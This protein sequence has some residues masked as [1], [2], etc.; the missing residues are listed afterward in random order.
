MSNIKT[1]SKAEAIQ[2]NEMPQPLTKSEDAQPSTSREERMREL[3]KDRPIYVNSIAAGLLGLDHGSVL[4]EMQNARGEMIRFYMSEQGGKLSAEEARIRVDTYLEDV[5][6]AV[7]H[8]LSQPADMSTWYGL[9]K[10]YAKSPAHAKTVWR[11][12]KDE[13]RLEFESGHRAAKVFEPVHWLREAWRRAQYIAIRESF[14]EQWKPQGGIDLAMIDMLTQSFYL[15]LYWN[16][17]SVTRTETE[18]RAD[19]PDWI[20]ERAYRD[21]QFP[22]ERGHGYWNPPYAHE[23]EAVEHAAQMADRYQRAFQRTLRAMRDLRRYSTPV[24]INN[25]Q[26]VN[27]AADGGRQVNAMKVGAHA[28]DSEPKIDKQ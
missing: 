22:R 28:I 17:V 9:E 13:A 18:V 5:D 23:Q 16:E 4:R 10:L 19:P 26:Q 7:S 15:Y 27:I 3:L 14:I 2:P 11:L 20:K 8:L 1:K 21:Q 24:T 6:E 12:I 25:P